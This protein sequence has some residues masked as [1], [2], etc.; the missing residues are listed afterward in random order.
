MVLP[1]QKPHTLSSSAE[2]ETQDYV[3]CQ[4][5]EVDDDKCLEE[6]GFVPSAMSES[7]GWHEPL[8]DKL[9]WDKKC[10]EEGVKFLLQKNDLASIVVEADGNLYMINHC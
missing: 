5:M 8:R 6:M 3:S 2:S 10:N 4:D 1:S 7:A 9:L